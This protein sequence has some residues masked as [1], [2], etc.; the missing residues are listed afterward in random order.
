MVHG[1]TTA[2]AHPPGIFQ[3]MA[4]VLE[5]PWDVEFKDLVCSPASGTSYLVAD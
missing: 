1:P 4:D 3:K 2:R 5:R